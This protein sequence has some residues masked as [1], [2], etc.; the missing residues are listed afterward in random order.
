MP[1]DDEHSRSMVWGG[2]DISF[3]Q[4]SYFFLDGI[5]LEFWALDGG[6]GQLAEI[7]Q[8]ALVFSSIV[9]SVLSITTW[10]F[11][12]NRASLCADIDLHFP[13]SQ[14]LVLG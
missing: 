11:D 10:F 1:V 5:S 4:K 14:F 8:W 6:L 13:R 9:K 12:V 7:V 2:S 3:C